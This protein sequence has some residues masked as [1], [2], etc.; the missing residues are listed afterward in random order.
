MR[1]RLNPPLTS[2]SSTSAARSPT[3]KFPLR[4][5]P[6]RAK[7]ERQS[8]K[9]AAKPRP[10]RSGSNGHDAGKENNPPPP[11]LPRARGVAVDP[12]QQ[13]GAQRSATK[14]VRHRHVGADPRVRPPY[15]TASRSDPSSSSARPAGAAPTPPGTA[16][17]GTPGG[18]LAGDSSQR[19]HIM[20][21]FFFSCPP[22]NHTQTHT[23]P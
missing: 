7:R 20:Q 9:A 15:P 3:F 16:A 10:S 5:S 17:P 13:D 22:N 6:K 14:R 21:F 2:P 12:A 19:Q 4:P 18:K 23:R 8:Q 1:E 11:R